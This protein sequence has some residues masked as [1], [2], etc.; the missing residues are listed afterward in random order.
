MEA[1]LVNQWSKKQHKRP[2]RCYRAFLLSIWP[3]GTIFVV[4]SGHPRFSSTP[5]LRGTLTLSLFRHLMLQ[6][7][8]PFPSSV[9]LP[10]YSKPPLP[11]SLTLKIHRDLD[12]CDGP[13]AHLATC[14][15][16]SLPRQF[17]VPDERCSVTR[18]GS[19]FDKV[20]PWLPHLR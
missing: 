14:D 12:V 15:S 20:L 1:C 13:Y 17:G 5:W 8:P 4:E 10:S 7:D 2:L 16:A 11:R 18:T 3:V 9:F 6:I 19:S